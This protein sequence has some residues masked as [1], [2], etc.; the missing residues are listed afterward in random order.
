MSIIWVP[1]LFCLGFM[2][3]VLICMAIV[4]EWI[5]RACSR[6]TPDKKDS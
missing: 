1:Q 5:A 6:K 4:M 3:A 2:L